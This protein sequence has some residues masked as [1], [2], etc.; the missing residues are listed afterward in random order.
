MYLS[1]NP[2]IIRI[3]KIKMAHKEENACILL[4]GGE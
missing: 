3:A 2:F 4:T 1:Q